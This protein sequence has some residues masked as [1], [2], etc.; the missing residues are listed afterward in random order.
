MK[1]AATKE[2]VDQLI[3]DFQPISAFGNGLIFG[4][5]TKETQFAIPI[6]IQSKSMVVQIFSNV[7]MIILKKFQSNN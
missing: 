1:D 7:E 6:Q 3:P 5:K 2:N 4:T